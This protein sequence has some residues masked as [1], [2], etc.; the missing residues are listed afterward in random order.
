[1]PNK[2]RFQSVRTYGYKRTVKTPQMRFCGVVFLE[3]VGKAA[4]IV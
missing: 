3:H 1:M 4:A 2:G